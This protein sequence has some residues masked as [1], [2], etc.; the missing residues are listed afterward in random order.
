MFFIVIRRDETYARSQRLNILV[1][2]L[3]EN[4]LS[5]NRDALIRLYNRMVDLE[6]DL[7]WGSKRKLED[8]LKDWHKE[9][10]FLYSGLADAMRPLYN[11]EKI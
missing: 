8:A 2:T 4:R 11:I 6:G 3:K 10:K 1:E 7:R 9:D 5:F